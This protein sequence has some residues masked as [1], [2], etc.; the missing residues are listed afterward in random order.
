MTTKCYH[1]FDNWLL[2][3]Q[4]QKAGK[5]GYA[6]RGGIFHKELFSYVLQN[7]PGRKM[8]LVI[9][10]TGRKRARLK[11]GKRRNTPLILE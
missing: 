7:E 4:C 9:Q 2:Y 5:C 11:N 10:G 1:I 6:D 3:M 8:G